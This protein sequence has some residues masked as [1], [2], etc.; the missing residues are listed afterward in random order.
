MLAEANL[1]SKS[2]T[3]LNNYFYYHRVVTVFTTCFTELCRVVSIGTG[4]DK[5]YKH[6]Y[7]FP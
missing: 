3:W 5:Q 6:M 7:I 4:T 1:P 2:I